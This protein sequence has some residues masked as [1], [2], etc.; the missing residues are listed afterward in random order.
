MTDL[1]REGGPNRIERT[2]TDQYRL[3]VSLPA[4]ADGMNARECP[5]ADC[6]PALFKT[7]PGTGLANQTAAF[8]PYCRHEAE[9]SDFTTPAQR[10]Y[11]IAVA[12]GEAIDGVNRMLAEALGLNSSN[13]KRLAD[14]LIKIDME[15]KPATKPFIRP[16]PGEEFRRDLLCPHC[17]LG[18]AVY[19]LAV[20][21]PDCGKDIFTTHVRE[22][23][24]V[25]GKMLV[26]IPDRLSTLGARVAARDLENALEDIVSIFEASMKALLRRHLAT[27]GKPDPEVDEIMRKV[28]GNRFQNPLLGA[29]AYKA[30]T[31]F[32]LLDCLA[33]TERTGLVAAFAKRHPIAHNLGV[34]D[35]KYLVAT[36]SAVRRS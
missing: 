3:T 11:A 32:D 30:L 2:G 18:H 16:P 26:A 4:D 36:R 21:C 33:D 27:S 25:V 19:G 28:V 24:V 5:A 34:V 1:L 13:K 17:S 29:E 31:E 9:P 23:L 10:A 15:L 6:S 12:K 14:G 7:R 35:R 22:E 8:C 20:W